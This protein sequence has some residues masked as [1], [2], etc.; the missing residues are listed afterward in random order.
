MVAVEFGEQRSVDGSYTAKAGC[1]AAVTKAAQ[2]RNMILLT[3][4][5]FPLSIIVMSDVFAEH[6]RAC[7]G[8]AVSLIHWCFHTCMSMS[9]SQHD[10]RLLCS[11]CS[12]MPIQVLTITC[13]TITLESTQQLSK[14]C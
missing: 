5:Q 8:C 3:A 10:G 2:K 14:A 1:A 13:T 11:L 12:S 7:L 9:H 6:S 4:G